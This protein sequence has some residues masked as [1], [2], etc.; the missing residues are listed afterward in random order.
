MGPLARSKTMLSPEGKKAG[1]TSLSPSDPA[2]GQLPQAAAVD[3][4][5]E[6]PTHHL[7]MGEGKATRHLARE[8]DRPPV[9][10]D[11]GIGV[12]GINS[13]HARRAGDLRLEDPQPRRQVAGLIRQLSPADAEVDNRPVAPGPGG[14]CAV[15][16]EGGDHKRGGERGKK[17][18]YGTVST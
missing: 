7:R 12:G 16:K 18:S 3:A 10:R 1:S 5:D 8:D 17:G 6:K 2:A 9:R 15:P 11:L 14:G 13:E 4:D